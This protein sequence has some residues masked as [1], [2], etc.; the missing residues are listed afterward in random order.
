MSVLPLAKPENISNLLHMDQ[1][2][3]VPAIVADNVLQKNWN[4]ERDRSFNDPEGFWGDYA[5]N[6]AW[7]QPWSKVLEWDGV[8]HKW[9]TGAQDQHHHQRARPPRQL[10]ARQSRR[11][12]LARRGRLRAHRHLRPALPPGLP[13]RQR[14]E[15]AGRGEGRP[16][17]HLHAAHHRGRDRHAGLR[18]HRRD[19]FRRLCR[20]RTHR[21]PRP[22]HRRASQNRDRRETSA[23][24]AARPSLSKPSSTKLSRRSTA[25]RKSS[26]IPRA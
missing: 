15:V 6:F 17:H 8:H 14:P 12:H 23:T 3:A 20:A 2:Y 21:A 16:R 11:L 5:R 19:S 4:G 1:E 26:S 10:R 13:L 18:P 25:S 9:F 7:S 22:H 24:A